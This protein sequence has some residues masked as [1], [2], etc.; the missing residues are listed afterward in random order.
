[1]HVVTGRLPK[2]YKCAS[3]NLKKHQVHLSFNQST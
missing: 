3:F 1:M 2:L